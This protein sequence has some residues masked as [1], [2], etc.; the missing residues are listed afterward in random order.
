M[1][2]VRAGFGAQTKSQMKDMTRTFTL[3]DICKTKFAEGF[4][5][6]GAVRLVRVKSLFEIRSTFCHCQLLRTLA[7]LPMVN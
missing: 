6:A 2:P 7:G 5:G 4:S 3:R 1:H